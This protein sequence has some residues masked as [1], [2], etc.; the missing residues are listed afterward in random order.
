RGTVVASRKRTRGGQ[1]AEARIARAQIAQEGIE[2]IGRAQRARHIAEFGLGRGRRYRHH[3][4]RAPVRSGPHPGRVFAA[5]PGE[6]DYVI[7]ERIA[8]AAAQDGDSLL[9]V[10]RL[11]LT[12]AIAIEELDLL[13][14]L[15]PA[16]GRPIDVGAQPDRLG[17]RYIGDDL[18]RHIV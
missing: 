11:E 4:E 10:E 14:G 8:Y 16:L 1:R 3:I 15:R 2:R 9:F 18:D 7:A 17:T 6:A 5:K 12:P 13:A